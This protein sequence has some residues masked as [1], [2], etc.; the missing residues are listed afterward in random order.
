MSKQIPPEVYELLQAL[1]I[2]DFC[3]GQYVEGYGCIL[4]ELTVTLFESRYNEIFYDVEYG[5][6]VVHEITRPE[7]IPADAFG[8]IVLHNSTGAKGLGHAALL[9]GNERTGWT[10]VS[11]DGYESGSLGPLGSPSK[12]IVKEFRSF[13]QFKASAHNQILKDEY[14]HTTTGGAEIDSLNYRVK[15]DDNG[16]PIE[17]YNKET[18]IPSKAMYNFTALRAAI[19][20]AKSTYILTVQDC[21]H[22]ITDALNATR[23]TIKNGELYWY[24]PENLIPI[25]R[26]L[27]KAPE[28]KYER[29]QKR[30]PDAREIK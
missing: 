8:I 30:N 1:G 3:A 27:E 14:V 15:R 19:R 18:F 20:S 4:P 7:A 29:I 24:S 13:A 12:Y 23:G 25:I 17:R 21:S 6:Y 2:T 11:K 22:V 28:D 10:Y 9:I 26:E 5:N 16:Y